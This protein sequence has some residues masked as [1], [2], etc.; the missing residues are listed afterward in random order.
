M[1]ARRQTFGEILRI[2][3]LTPRILLFRRSLADY[4]RFSL[5]RLPT[6]DSPATPASPPDATQICVRPPSS[7]TAEQEHS[8]VRA[9]RPSR[10]PG[11]ALK[12]ESIP[13]A[14]P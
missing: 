6:E 1:D 3:V 4:P 7:C 11:R 14:P 8:I 12:A 2:P 9:A 13:R 10:P 5:R